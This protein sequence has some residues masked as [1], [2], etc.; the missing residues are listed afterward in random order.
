MYIILYTLPRVGI[1]RQ[2]VFERSLTRTRRA[3][4]VAFG[5]L[6]LF[7]TQRR[8]YAIKREQPAILRVTKYPVFVLSRR[9]QLTTLHHYCIYIPIYVCFGRNKNK[10]N[11]ILYHYFQTE[12]NIQVI[13]T[14]I[15][16]LFFSQFFFYILPVNHIIIPIIFTITLVPNIVCKQF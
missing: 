13:G 15:Q 8:C 2:N 7:C 5:F 9:R 10:G 11:A 1:D 6:V 14:Y 12:H 4:R 3:R 16:V